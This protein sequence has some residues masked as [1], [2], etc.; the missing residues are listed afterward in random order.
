MH[1]G[2]YHAFCPTHFLLS[3]TWDL[4]FLFRRTASA[5]QPLFSNKRE[6]HLGLMTEAE[7]GK[8]ELCLHPKYYLPSYLQQRTAV[9]FA[10]F[11][12]RRR[13]AGDMRAIRLPTTFARHRHFAAEGMI[14]PYLYSPAGQS[15]VWMWT[16][17]GTLIV[18]STIRLR[19]RPAA[20]VT[21][22]RRW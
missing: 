12:R 14:L 5:F 21:R 22:L 9:T 11:T 13:Y 20:P 16:L 2:T 1:Y 3:H 17:D 18:V 4:S 15:W 6:E 10:A 7:A 19:H 8:A